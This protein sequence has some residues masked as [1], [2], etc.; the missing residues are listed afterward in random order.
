MPHLIAGAARVPDQPPKP[1]R[2]PGPG[3][4]ADARRNLDKLRAAAAGACSERGLDTPLEQIAAR[5]GVSIGILY[6]RLGP[7]ETLIDA[8][9]ADPAA[10]LVAAAE[11]AQTI[12]DPWGR[13]ARYLEQ[14]CAI[15]ATDLAFN[16][17]LARR[18]PEAEQ[19]SAA[20]DDALARAGAYLQQAQRAGTVRPDVTVQDIFLIFWSNANIIR[21]THAV[22][23]GAWRRSLALTLD[24]LR[25][26]AAHPRPPRPDPQ[27]GCRHQ[28]RHRAHRAEHRTHDRLSARRSQSGRPRGG[29]TPRSL[30]ASRPRPS[31]RAP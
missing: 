8:V 18:R 14:I 29:G 23:P 21:A 28:P 1:P 31:A 22:A 13:F 27:Q 15:Q 16:D 11:T 7:R 12:T 2:R 3:L 25:T 5:A 4:R 9:I 24:G 26:E 17:V 30:G 6:N 10:A 20:C 19:T